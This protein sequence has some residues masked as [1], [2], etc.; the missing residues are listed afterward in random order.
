MEYYMFDLWNL[1][2]EIEGQAGK[3][4]MLSDGGE[5]GE[6]CRQQ[7][8]LHSMVPEKAYRVWTSTRVF[9]YWHHMRRAIICIATVSQVHQSVQLYQ[10]H[11]KL[12]HGIVQQDIKAGKTM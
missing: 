11:F 5:Q 12:C 7:M 9:I 3:Q 1:L 4:N 10:D 2:A 8:M 6:M